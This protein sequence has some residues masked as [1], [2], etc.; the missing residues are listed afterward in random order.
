MTKSDLVDQIAKKTGS[1]KAAAEKV[2]QGFLGSVQEA[3]V[4]DGKITL[5]GFGTFSVE[6]RK[7]RTGRNPRTGEPMKI[8]ATNV[9]KFRAGKNLKES[10]K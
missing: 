7:A 1:T 6:T 5:T 2:L 8:P 10:V 9:V 3:L 4:K